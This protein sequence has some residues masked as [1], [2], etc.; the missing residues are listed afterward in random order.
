MAFFETE[1]EL[2]A[3]EIYD[4]NGRRI[5]LEGYPLLNGEGLYSLDLGLLEPGIRIIR[6]RY[7]DDT[8]NTVRIKVE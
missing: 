3:Y 2:E 8:M 5:H 1:K 4:M 6:F 7:T